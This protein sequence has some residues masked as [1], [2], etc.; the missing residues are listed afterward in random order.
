MIPHEA[1]NWQ[2][3]SSLSAFLKLSCV[4][5][6]RQPEVQCCSLSTNIMAFCTWQNFS[7]RWFW[8]L[9]TSCVHGTMPMAGEQG[10]VTEWTASHPG[11]CSLEYMQWRTAFLA[12]LTLKVYWMW[13][14]RMVNSWACNVYCGFKV[15][16]EFV[17]LVLK[18]KMGWDVTPTLPF[19]LKQSDLLDMGELLHS[20]SLW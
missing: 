6:I 3:C 19:S 20:A 5:Q 13:M 2:R 18:D 4:F 16:Y 14:Y 17:S 1:S 12:A 9:L 8:F 11:S 15:K 10:P 7:P